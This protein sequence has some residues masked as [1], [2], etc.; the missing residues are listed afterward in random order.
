MT[1]REAYIVLNQIEGIGPVRVRALGEALGAPEAV[2]AAP[3][4]ALAAVRGI[5]PKVAAS[6]VAQRDELDAARE[7]HAAAQLGARLV[8][9]VDADYPAPL[10]NIYDPP[11]CLYVHNT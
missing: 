10:K 2:L 1:S 8:T 3:A 11:L 5:G 9:P 7:E 4:A 6:I